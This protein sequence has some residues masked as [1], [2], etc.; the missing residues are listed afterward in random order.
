M[1]NFRNQIVVIGARES[2]KKLDEIAYEVG[3]EIA[4]NNC[5]L[6]CG[7]REGIMEAACKGAKKY[8]GTTI[9]IM[10]EKTTEKANK[11]L[12]III[13]TGI[14]FARNYIVQNSGS[15]VIMIGGSY[16]TLSELA[17]ALQFGKK[18]VSLKSQWAKIDK[19]III[20][21]NAKDAVLKAIS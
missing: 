7:G 18:V 17:Y 11:Y 20:A 10:P 2:T 13:P 21:T 15:A 3:I 14:G 8:G 12:D 19:K 1:S 9:G 4:K 5:I 16:G 6:I